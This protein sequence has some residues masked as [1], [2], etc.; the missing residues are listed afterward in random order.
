MVGVTS[1]DYIKST[2]EEILQEFGILS[3]DIVFVTDNGSNVVAAFKDYIQ[4]SC[5]GR[6]INLVL[7]HVFDHLD[8]D[9]PLHSPIIKLLAET[10]TLVTHFKR[11]GLHKGLDQSLKQ[12]RWNSK[13]AM[14]KSVNDAL[15]SGKLHDILLRRNEL[16]FPNNIDSELLDDLITL[17]TPFDEA[18]RYLSTETLPAK[19]TLPRGLV[20]QDEDKEI[21]T[22][23]KKKLAQAA[24][25]KFKIHL[26]HKVAAA[27]S[28]LA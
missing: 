17:L 28:L 12:A 9:N 13:L 19:A 25:L 23:L 27:I 24:D 8:Q 7:K 3:E 15:K 2:V 10:K 16:R 14:L 6:N 26:Y 1:N 11:A 21:V 22:E 18:T 20:H 5:A 4:L